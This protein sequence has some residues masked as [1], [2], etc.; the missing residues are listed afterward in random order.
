MFFVCLFLIQIQPVSAQKERG[1]GMWRW[2]WKPIYSQHLLPIFIFTFLCC[3]FTCQ[4][5]TKISFPY[6]LQQELDV[7]IVPNF[8]LLGFFRRLPPDAGTSSTC[9]WS[10][11]ISPPICIS[12]RRIYL[13]NKVCH[14]YETHVASATWSYSESE[15]FTNAAWQ[16]YTV[17]EHH[18]SF[19][20]WSNVCKLWNIDSQRIY[21]AAA[22]MNPVSS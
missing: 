3:C 22:C 11:W 10:G 2:K 18:V 13:S 4:K 14:C 1:G 19:P 8:V 6:V 7:R 15:S 9:D 21:S 17:Y 5:L 20:A 12:R 16:W